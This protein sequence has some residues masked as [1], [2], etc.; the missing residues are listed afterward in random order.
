MKL[1]FATLS[2]CTI[3][4]IGCG[5]NSSTA[6]I[7]TSHTVQPTVLVNDSMTMLKE[8]NKIRASLYSGHSLTWSKS[9]EHTAQIHA[10]TLARSNT[11]RHSGTKNGENLF[12]TSGKGGYVSALN[13]WYGEK[14]DYSLG[15]NRCKPS[16]VCGHY[17][18]LVW[19]DTKEVG[20]A[21][22]KSS[23]GGTFIVCQYSP[24]GNYRGQKPY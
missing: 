1:H 23:S 11:F 19:K 4:L 13:A 5:G 18:Q 20:C 2:L 9:L 7:I 16:K 8:N 10:N 15:T 24:P 12:A 3:L 6:Q 17:T 21:Q 22:A 14:K